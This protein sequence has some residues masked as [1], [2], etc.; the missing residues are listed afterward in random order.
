MSRSWGNLEQLWRHLTANSQCLWGGNGV[1]VAMRGRATR[2][3]GQQYELK[4]EGFRLGTETFP[5]GGQAGQQ[6]A[7]G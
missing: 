4:R 3:Q 1:R 2:Q 7:E 5:P 6:A